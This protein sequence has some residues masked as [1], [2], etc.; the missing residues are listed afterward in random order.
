MQ[1][2]LVF[3]TVCAHVAGPKNL[4]DDRALPLGMGRDC[5]TMPNLII[6]G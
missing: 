6:L 4:G 1:N 3:R 2:W 5:L